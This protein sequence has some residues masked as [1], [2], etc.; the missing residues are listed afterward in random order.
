MDQAVID[1]IARWPDVP[2]VYGWLSLDGRGRW[3]LHPDGAATRGGPGEPIA[4]TQILAF[5]DRNYAQEDGRWYFQNG[6]QRV[7]VRL[8]AAP[9]VLR[10]APRG[11]GLQTHTGLDVAGVDAW[12]LDDG[13]RLYAATDLGP[14]M[15]EDRDLMPL[16][17]ALRTDDGRPVLEV[18]ER[19][20]GGAAMR[21]AAGPGW[22]AA[23]LHEIARTEVAAR[24]R[25][26][27]NPLP[28]AGALPVE[29]PS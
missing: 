17:E 14:G 21:V 26:F 11:D 20:R 15:V 24:L 6:P 7:Y 25:F 10:R 16:L 12:W 27:P 28:P 5:I 8:D 13:G 3:R 22:P 2:A 9:Y 4:N 19:P 23:P 29:S 18:L 1:A